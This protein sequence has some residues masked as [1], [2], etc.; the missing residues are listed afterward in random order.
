MARVIVLFRTNDAEGYAAR[1]K[2]RLLPRFGP[3]RVL[4]TP[5]VPHPG[6]AVIALI[7][8]AWLR[9]PGANGGRALDD[10]NDPVR[11]VLAEALQLRLSV[12]AVFLDRTP[13]PPADLLPEPV[14]GILTCPSFEMSLGNFHQDADAVISRLPT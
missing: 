4:D 8:R 5:V 10:P 14:R 3:S 9:A 11:M 1:L 12:I 7:G 13:R 2:A 6:D